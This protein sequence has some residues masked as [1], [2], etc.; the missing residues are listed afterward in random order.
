MT[1]TPEKP[2]KKPAAQKTASATAQKATAKKAAAPKKPAIK[3]AAPKKPAVKKPAAA[4][5]PTARKTPAKKPAAKKAAPKKP[6]LPPPLDLIQT[7]LLDKKGEDIAILRVADISSVTDY[8]VLCTGRNIHHLSAMA[9]ELVNRLRHATPSRVPHQRAGAR[10]T[11]WV[12]L[13]Y[14][15]IVVH[16]FTPAL[17]SYY[18]LEQ[19]WKDAPRLPLP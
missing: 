14:L 13:D 5:K 11:E 15:D 9:D 3:K 17:R 10:Q 2:A 7:A 4:K 16:L 1:P 19:L 18:A 12:V 8:M 6:V